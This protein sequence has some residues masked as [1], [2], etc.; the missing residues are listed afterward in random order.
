MV[1]SDYLYFKIIGVADSD[2]D[3]YGAKFIGYEKF[4]VVFIVKCKH[5]SNSIFALGVYIYVAYIKAFKDKYSFV[6][7]FSISCNKAQKI[8]PVFNCFVPAAF[9]A[10]SKHYSAFDKLIIKNISYFNG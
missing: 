10:D 6:P 9:I 2:G 8:I 5:S 3:F 4:I 7:V 1:L